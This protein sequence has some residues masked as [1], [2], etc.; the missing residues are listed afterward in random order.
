ML[1]W[2]CTCHKQ[3]LASQVSN[4][5]KNSYMIN[6]CLITKYGLTYRLK[7]IEKVIDKKVIIFTVNDAQTLFLLQNESKDN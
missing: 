1:K 6:L 2:Q 5:I 7:L 3:N 4:T